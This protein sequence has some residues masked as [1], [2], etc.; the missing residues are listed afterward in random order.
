MKDFADDRS[1]TRLQREA[2]AVS[3]LV[4]QGWRVTIRGNCVRCV[5]PVG[6]DDLLYTRAT[7]KTRTAALRAAVAAAYLRQA[8]AFTDAAAGATGDERRD[9]LAAARENARLARRV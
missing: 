8:E 1:A 4:Q 9:L 7:R 6:D 2:I 3:A 5:K